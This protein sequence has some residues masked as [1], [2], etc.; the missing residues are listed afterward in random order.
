MQ[1]WGLS[2]TRN[3]FIVKSTTRCE[4]TPSE[5]CSMQANTGRDARIAPSTQRARPHTAL[6]TTTAAATFGDALPNVGPDE[7]VPGL[8]R[9]ILHSPSDCHDDVAQRME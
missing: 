8:F 6:R 2:P 4:R 1:A 9:V 5:Q 7:G 3:H